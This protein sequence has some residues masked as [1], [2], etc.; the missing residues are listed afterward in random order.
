[1]RVGEPRFGGGDETI[2]NQDAML[3]SEMT[4]YRDVPDSRLPRQRKRILR[5]FITVRDVKRGGQGR[6]LADLVRS[7]N[8]GDFQHLGLIRLQIGERDCTVGCSKVDAKTE[9]CAHDLQVFG[10]VVCKTFLA[11]GAVTYGW[12][13]GHLVVV[14]LAAGNA[15]CRTAALLAAY[16]SSTSAGAIVGSRSSTRTIRGSLTDSV[17]QPR[18]TSVPENGAAPLIL[19]MRRYSSAGYPTAMVTEDPSLSWRTG[20]I[21]KCSC[22]AAL[23]P[24]CTTRAAAP[25]WASSYVVISS[26]GPSSGCRRAAQS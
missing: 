16:F 17:F 10:C 7:K 9:T 20:R 26:I 11:G 22:R 15:P 4:G 25:T 12:T 13:S 19:P 1:M 24:W 5:K 8:L 2:R 21:L 18:W 14:V 3:A 23:H 6:L